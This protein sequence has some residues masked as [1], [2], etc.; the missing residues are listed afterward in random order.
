MSNTNDKYELLCKSTDDD[1]MLNKEKVLLPFKYNNRSDKLNNSI[2][3]NNIIKFILIII[4]TTLG[5]ILIGS[6]LMRNFNIILKK[7]KSITIR[8]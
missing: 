3:T 6:W 5:V 7:N 1:K 2:L 4:G 8:K